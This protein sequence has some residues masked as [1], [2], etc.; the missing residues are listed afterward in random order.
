MIQ[1]YLKLSLRLLL[2][3]PF[4]TFIHIAG[5]S[6]GLAT[7]ML[8]WPLA[9]FELKSD[10]Y[11]K[12]ADRI[13]RVGVDY[14]WTDD[15]QTWEGFN[16]AFNYIGVTYEMEQTMAQVESGTWIIPQNY[17]QEPYI[18]LNQNVFF[19]VISKANERT[20][21]RETQ[22][23]VS[24]PNLFEFFT[25]P[26]I[27]G[28]PADV[29]K[30][31]NTIVL[32]E[33]MVRKYFGD[34][35][36]LG[37]TIYLND[38]TPLLVTGVFKDLP[39]NTHLDFNM[40][41]S[42]TG[43]EGINVKDMSSW[44]AYCYLKL[45]EGETIHSFLEALKS[46]QQSLY[47][48]TRRQCAHC[49]IK[50]LPQRLTDVVF[51]NWRA[52][53]FT[54]KSK[55]LI[56]ALAIVAFVV[57]GFAW[58][59]YISLSVNALNKRL[60]EIGTRKSVGAKANDFFFQFLIESLVMNAISFGIALT[61]IQIMGHMAEDWFGFYIPNWSEIS[62]LTTITILST[63]GIGVFVAT[64]FPLVL[65]TQRKP[66]ELFKKLKNH[67]KS[68]GVNTVLVGIQ[69]GV[70]T[71][72]LVWIGAVYFQL[73]FLLNKDIGIERDGLIVVDGPMSMSN[74][75]L[76]KIPSFLNEVKRISGISQATQS[77]STLADLD[78][79]GLNI[80]RRGSDIW[81]GADTN[82]GVDESFLETYNVP[83]VAGRNFQADNPSD[84]NNIL[85]S[86]ALA[87]RLAFASPS[88]AIGKKVLIVE[89]GSEKEVE[90]VGVFS[91]YEFRPFFSDITERDRG[92][93]LTYK[94]F[95]VPFF[96]PWKF[97]IKIE[98]QDL[99]NTIPEIERL[100]LSTFHE[101]FKWFFLDEKIRMQY[102]DE[103]ATKNQ[104]A[105]FSI[106]AVGITCLGLLGM[107][108]N[109]VMEKTKEIGIRKV[110]GARMHQIA[111]LLLN[112]TFRQI[113]VANLVGI[114]IAYYLVTQYL[115]K[116]SEHLT[117][118]WW[119]YVLPVV[120]LLLIMFSTVAMVLLRAART[121]PTESLRYE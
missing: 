7:F 86:K 82:G 107:I 58:I 45:K 53:V 9:E 20:S 96:K 71:V 118:Q 49:N 60:T 8:L 87:G 77:H 64:L 16:G 6:I 31:P 48:F 72:L 80:K 79:G 28:D 68:G 15:N 12:D 100:Y 1:N 36:G 19:T 98:L 56:E 34:G 121:N 94:N 115:E 62:L 106:L 91:D 110:L 18:G 63:L 55:F 81:F 104:I 99:D 59:N 37:Q 109:K 102:A 44:I 74:T 120:L 113:V 47:D 3:N 116:F 11:H 85:I 84:Q 89:S 93:L 41:L 25:I 73:N 90:I 61:L 76:A 32:S 43:Y 97:S 5:L 10:Q 54:Y 119:H 50:A 51:S 117:L 26:L 78:D 30:N 112:T 57:L 95:V 52:N 114:P 21:F 108:T 92:V 46:R 17:F 103:Q 67:I 38:T 111:H 105:F 2:R 88:E 40:V 22:T 101:P 75:N 65:I 66:T 14:Q 24:A 13:V 35:K 27:E 33:T 4:L 70:A 83:L 42:S 39:H 29:L 23:V 69:Y